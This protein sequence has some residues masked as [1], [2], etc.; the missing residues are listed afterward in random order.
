MRLS[1][2]T[3]HPGQAILILRKTLAS[4]LTLVQTQCWVFPL[5]FKANPINLMHA[6]HPTKERKLRSASYLRA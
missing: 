5:H 2:R 1:Y 6:L 3:D 4:A